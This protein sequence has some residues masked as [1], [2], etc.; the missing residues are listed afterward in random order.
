MGGED[1]DLAVV[2]DGFGVGLVVQRRSSLAAELDLLGTLDFHQTH[3]SVDVHVEKAFVLLHLVDDL[4]LGLVLDCQTKS[5]LLER[6]VPGQTTP[7]KLCA[8]NLGF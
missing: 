6:S 2:G 8:R 7:G 1:L 5:D 3:A 4:N